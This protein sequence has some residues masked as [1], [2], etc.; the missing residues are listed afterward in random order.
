MSLQ[1]AIEEAL[2]A[3]I[4]PELG[5]N[6]VDLGMVYGIAV[7]DDGNVAVLMTT[8]ARFC[9]ASSFLRDAVDAAA[10]EVDGVRSVEVSLTYD[11]PWTPDRMAPAIAM[12][13]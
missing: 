11:P 7:D 12:R 8:T 13:F 9:P 6:I 3:V 4:D 10:S 5:H 1:A 2:R